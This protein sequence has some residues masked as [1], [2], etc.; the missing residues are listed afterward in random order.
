[1][2]LETLPIAI[3]LIVAGVVLAIWAMIQSSREESQQQGP[4]GFS[5]DQLGLKIMANAAG[6]MLL[7]GVAVTGAGIFLLIK[8]Y[9]DKLE[10]LQK[11]TTGLKQTLSEFKVY[12]LV[13]YPKFDEHDAPNILTAPLKAYM[14]RKGARDE[15]SYD[16]F[17]NPTTGPGGMKVTVSKLGEGD[18]IYFV[19]EEKGRKW[20]SD[21]FSAGEVPQLKMNLLP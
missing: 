21:D 7:L 17:T 14:R 1:L 2:R 19:V 10:E 16:E 9:D 12:D 18:T 20:R 8:K 4:I 13:V 11:E 3:G 15:C 5:F 6:W